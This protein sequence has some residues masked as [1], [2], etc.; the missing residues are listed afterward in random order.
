MLFGQKLSGWFWLGLSGVHVN[1]IIIM[2][3]ALAK[4]KLTNAF[5]SE[6]T[7]APT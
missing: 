5:W 1:L 7:T 2:K 4:T 3:V 6:N